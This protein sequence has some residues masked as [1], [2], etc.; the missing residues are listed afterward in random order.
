MSD[1]RRCA[2]TA[3][4]VVG[5]STSGHVLGGGA[6]PSLV[7]AALVTTLAVVLAA[8][9]TNTTRP[10]HPVVLTPVLGAFQAFAHAVFHVVDGTGVVDVAAHAGHP[11]HAAAASHVAGGLRAAAGPTSEVV[12]HTATH[13]HAMGL[14]PLMVTSHLLATV[15]LAWLLGPAVRQVRTLVRRATPH[16]PVIAARVPLPASFA[17][18]PLVVSRDVVAAVGLRGPPGLLRA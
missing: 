17:H 9:V 8:L 13:A 1:L 14:S 16:V 4:A 6:S 10:L 2:W 11:G 7:A 18:P 3:A 15:L 12:T 5:L